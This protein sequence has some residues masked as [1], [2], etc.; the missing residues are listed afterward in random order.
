ML[1]QF[2]IL[3]NE[4]FSLRH[5]EVLHHS[6]CSIIS[7]K[8][9]DL[10]SKKLKLKVLDVSTF[11]NL[12]NVDLAAMDFVPMVSERNPFEIMNN[13]VEMNCGDR[14]KKNFTKANMNKIFPCLD[15]RKELQKEREM[16]AAYKAEAEVSRNYSNDIVAELSHLEQKTLY[17]LNDQITT[18]QTQLKAS[19]NSLSEKSRAFNIARATITDVTSQN[20][21][22]KGY[23]CLRGLKF[24]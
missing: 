16:C 2:Y 15:L 24:F 9:K 23:F 11:A 12:N 1:F 14:L 19:E 17:E 4:T 8:S 6:F 22:L 10:V 18:L 7:W 3:K 20:E 5:S 21:S 13:E